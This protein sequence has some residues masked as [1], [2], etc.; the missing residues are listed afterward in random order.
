MK[1]KDVENS[2]SRKTVWRPSPG[3]FFKIHTKT[4]GFMRHCLGVCVVWRWGGFVFLA[5]AFVSGRNL[6]GNPFF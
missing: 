5:A 1:Q 2:V 4:E 3:V 6:M